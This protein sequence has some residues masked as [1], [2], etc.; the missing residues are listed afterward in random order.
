MV[1][2]ALTS[3]NGVTIFQHALSNENLKPALIDLAVG[4]IVYA[5]LAK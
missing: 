3:K 5:V 2:I 1:K 4:F